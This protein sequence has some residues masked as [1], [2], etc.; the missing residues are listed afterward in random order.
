MLDIIFARRDCEVTKL[1]YK[2]VKQFINQL[3]S[4][5]HDNKTS[6]KKKIVARQCISSHYRTNVHADA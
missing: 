4:Q 3:K 5:N 1:I 6:F 2:L